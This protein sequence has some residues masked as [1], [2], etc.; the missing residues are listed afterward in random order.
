MYKKD[1]INEEFRLKH[2]YYESGKKQKTEDFAIKA[3]AWCIL[4]IIGLMVLG[5]IL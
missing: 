2:S 5:A 3:I 4:G 1:K